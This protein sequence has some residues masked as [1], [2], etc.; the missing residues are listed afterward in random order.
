[1]NYLQAGPIIYFTSLPQSA[2]I[3]IK[4]LKKQA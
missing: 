1:M 4:T 3:L 2:Q